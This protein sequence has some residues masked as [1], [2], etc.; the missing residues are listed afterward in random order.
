MRNAIL[1]TI[2][3]LSFSVFA[4]T[5]YKAGNYKVDPM[6][7]KV[8]FDIAHLVV[9][10]VEGDFKDFE[11]NIDLKDKFE[12]SSVKATVEVSSVDTGVKRR[13]DDLRSPEFFDVKKH[14][15]MTFESTKIE[16]TPEH[17]KMTGKL[18]IKGVTKVVTFDGK[19]TGAVNDGM[20]NERVAFSATTTIKRKDFG[21]TWNKMIEAGPVVGDSL[22][23]TLKTEA[24]Q[25]AKIAKE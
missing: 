2:A 19:F 18:T 14:P 15:K 16:G 25:P 12:K 6:H 13:D 10:T 22:D 24:T 11:G 20:G 9:S 4:Q 5:K 17:F 8:R 21:L 1:T 23:I 3:L 7:S